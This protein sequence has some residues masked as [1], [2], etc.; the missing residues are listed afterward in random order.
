MLTLKLFNRIRNDERIDKSKAVQLVAYG[1]DTFITLG[2]VNLSCHLKISQ[3]NLEFHI[4]D[5]PVTPLIGL[6]D[7]LCLSLV[8]LHTEVHEVETADSFQ[9]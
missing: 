1:G 2:T 5:R 7:S 3:H 9:A 6:K 4:V 8:Q